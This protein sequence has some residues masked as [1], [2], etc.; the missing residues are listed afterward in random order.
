MGLVGEV[1][2]SGCHRL[3]HSLDKAAPPPV[4][5]TLDPSSPKDTEAAVES[6][7]VDEKRSCKRLHGLTQWTAGRRPVR[8]LLSSSSDAI[9]LWPEYL[10]RICKQDPQ[11]PKV[12]WRGPPRPDD[13]LQDVDA[14]CA[15]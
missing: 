7:L 1:E 11:K 10:R 15:G 6:F 5:L 14:P 8:P 2:L 12:F 4:L 3:P 13:Q 9:D